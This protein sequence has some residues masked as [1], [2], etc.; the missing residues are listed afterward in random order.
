[1][2]ILSVY[3]LLMS[4]LFSDIVAYV[5]VWSSNGTE[6][7][8]KTFTKQLENMGAKHKCMQPKDFIPKTPENNKRL[9]K[10]FEK[11]AE[12]LQR[13]KTTLGPGYSWMNNACSLLG[14]QQGSIVSAMIHDWDNT[15]WEE[16]GPE[17]SGMQGGGDGLSRI[18]LFESHSLVYSS[19]TP[20]RSHQSMMEKRLQEMKEKRENLSPTSSQMFEQA[21]QNPNTSLCEASLNVSRESLS[22]DESFASCSHTS[23]DDLCGNQEKKRR[24]SANEL[25]RKACSSSPV[26]KT[27]LSYDSALPNHLSQ[28]S[29]QK[30]T[31]R[32]PKEGTSWQKDAAGEQVDPERKQAAGVSQGVPDVLCLSPA[33]FALHGLKSSSAK[34]RRPA[35]LGSPPKG[36]PKKRYNGK[37]AL[38]PQLFKSDH[39]RQSMTGPFLGT[40]DVGASSYEDYFSPDNLKERNS[41][42]LPPK[43]LFHSRGLSKWER[44]NILEMCD[45]THIGKTP[46]PMSTTDL[47]SESTSSPEKPDEKE[48]STVSRCILGRTSATESPECDRQ[49]GLQLREATG[50]QG[51][52]HAD[53]QNSPAHFITPLK[54]GSKEAGEPIDVKCSPKD[55]TIPPT[56]A[57]SEGE[58]HTFNF[59]EDCKVGK[60]VEEKENIATGYSQSV[61]SEPLRPET[62]DSSG[63][64]LVRPH[65]KPKKCGKGQKVAVVW[66]SQ[67]LLDTGGYGVA[68]TGAVGHRWLW[69]GSHRSCWTQV[70]VVW[71]SQELLDTG[72]CGVAVTGAVGH[73][74]QTLIIQVVNT[75][76]G[77]SFTPEVCEST[78]HV[79]VGKSVRTLNVL[80]GIARGCWI[81]SYEWTLAVGDT[82]P[83]QDPAVT[84]MQVKGLQPQLCDEPASPAGMAAII[85]I[86]AM[87]FARYP[88]ISFLILLLTQGRGSVVT[89]CEKRHA[90]LE[91]GYQ[92]GVK[93]VTNE[94]DPIVDSEVLTQDV[95]THVCRL[96][97]QLSTQRYQGALFANQPKMFIA[98]ASSPPRAKLCELVLLCGGHVSPTPQLASLIIGPYRGKKEPRIQYLSEKWVLGS[99][100]EQKEVRL[101]QRSREAALCIQEGGEAIL[102]GPLSY[103]SLSQWK[104]DLYFQWR[105]VENLDW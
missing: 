72:G 28:P 59:G 43:A 68:V 50:P 77:F 1:M 13:Q 7:Y 104:K 103:M 84:T 56:S 81:L 40:P 51:S 46:R 99:E 38:T 64:D 52:T 48:V 32:P 9:Q 20:V 30:A 29:P 6:N 57:S 93:Q 76:K 23:F 19:S 63:S 55:R 33:L 27:S 31:D 45:F 5:E 87:T 41:E 86:T 79:L 60:S 37:S 24:K 71:L 82:S 10:K 39:S 2:A 62:S 89:A 94:V 12:E 92:T 49:P 14:A 102:E 67:E 11:M 88:E 36:T 44:R 66:L 17:G 105:N 80:M 34:R 90:V 21:Q 100:R 3:F 53:T 74:K 83:R 26:L 75:L 98:P 47:V 85:F 65:K 73:R 69:C 22:S 4:G 91:V 42:A 78:T 96:E 97:R 70:V 58:A 101:S 16:N 61:N 25:A 18:K 15:V 54:E 95:G 8:S 35:D